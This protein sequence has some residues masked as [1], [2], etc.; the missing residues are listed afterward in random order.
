MAVCEAEEKK[1]VIGMCTVCGRMLEEGDEATTSPKIVCKKCDE[2]QKQE[3]LKAQKEKERK[4]AAEAKAAEE[5]RQELIKEELGKG[6]DAKLIVALVLSVAAYVLFTILCF[7]S[8]TPDLMG[9][10]LLLVPLALFGATLAICNFVASLRDKD[11]EGYTRNLSLIVGGCFSVVNIVL[12]L[13]LYLTMGKSPIFIGL[14]AIGTIVSFT[15][16]SQFMWGSV[17][18][19]LFTGGGFT[20]K[21]PGIIFALDVDSIIMMIVLKIGLGILAIAVF[22][23]TTVLCAV[24]SILGSVITFIPCIIAKSVKDNK[25]RK[26]A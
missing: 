24:I 16:V 19:E 18:R 15:F 7:K 21:I 26:S 10:F 8:D 22:L 11:D 9:V 23:I 12:F 5:L 25:T 3:A 14:L 2:R 4:E 6:F 17:L 1:K 13:V 20:F